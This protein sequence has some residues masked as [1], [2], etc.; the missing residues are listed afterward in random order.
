MFL[1]FK[2]QNLLTFLLLKILNSAKNNS[3]AEGASVVELDN[4]GKVK[5]Y[6]SEHFVHKFAVT[7]NSSTAHIESC[8]KGLKGNDCTITL[9]NGYILKLS[10]WTS[11]GIWKVVVLPN[12][13]NKERRSFADVLTDSTVSLNDYEEREGE[14]P[15]EVKKT[16]EE[17]IEKDR[18]KISVNEIKVLDSTKFIMKPVDST[19]P[20]TITFENQYFF[21]N[22]AFILK[23]HVFFNQLD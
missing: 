10:C 21:Y 17:R 16:M 6:F 1:L 18:K 14:N 12:N 23:I 5:E 2:F 9:S 20:I 22:E 7:N 15:Q 8:R 19:N 13:Q 4:S 11:Q 3:F